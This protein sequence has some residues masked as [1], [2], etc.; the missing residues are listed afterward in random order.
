[1][2][3][4]GKD[5]VYDSFE[6]FMEVQGGRIWY[7][8]INSDRKKTP[9]VIVHGGP[10]GTHDYLESIGELSAERPVIFYD[11]LG[12]GNSERPEDESLYNINRFA[13]ELDTLLN[14]LG[15][16]S[17]NLL[18][19]SWGTMLIIE[20]M[21]SCRGNIKSLILSSP[22]LSAKRLIQ[23]IR[24][25]IS[26]LP[27]YAKK[28]IYYAEETGFY[29]LEYESAVY[30]F[31]KRHLCS[32]D[33]YPEPMQRTIDKM[34]FFVYGYMWGPSEITCNGIL[35]DFDRVKDLKKI[36]I[37]V[38]FTC[39]GLDEVTPKTTKYY[40]H[41]LPGSRVIVFENATHSH[42]FEKKEEYNK[43]ISEFLKE[44]E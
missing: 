5:C 21:L 42:H 12:G 1:M 33:P 14:V 4:P 27:D 15:F 7:K 19:F 38:L 20:Y 30:I 29:G 31:S 32:L 23:D 9:L 6:G 39:G 28:A 25:Y 11:Q 10:G 43:C 13:D 24:Y 37:P 35:K 18:G 34:S 40:S 8:V 44:N 2:S 16:D 26:K 17:Y 36:N 3:F 22:V 41:H